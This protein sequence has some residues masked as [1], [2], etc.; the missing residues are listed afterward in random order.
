MLTSMASKTSTIRA[1]LPVRGKGNTKCHIHKDNDVLLLC[2]DCKVLICLT[3]SLSTHKA[4]NGSFVELSET[5]YQN[6]NIIL[7]FINETDKVNIPKLNHEIT[8]SR[9]KITSCKP[10]YDKLRKDILD[11]SNQCKEELDLITAEYLS[12]CDMMEV[13]ATDRFQTHISEM[14][15][16]RE[17]LRELSSEYRQTIQT[18]TAIL[19]YDSVSE[20][21]ELDTDIPPAPTIDLAGFTPS[22]NRQSHIKQAMGNISIPTDRTESSSSPV[23]RP[24]QSAGQTSEVGYNLHPTVMSQFSYP[25]GVTSVCPTSDGYAWLCDCKN[26][27]V[28]LITYKGQVLQK[29]KHIENIRD[30]SLDPTTGRLWFCCR[31]GKIVCE[32][33]TSSTP[34]T[35]FTTEYRPYSLCVTREGRVVVGTGSREQGYKVVMYTTD[36]RMLHTAILKSSGIGFVQSITQC[37]VT[38]NIAVISSNY[39]SGD[40]ANPHN[41]IRHVIVYNQ[42]LQDLVIYRGEDI[43][44]TRWSYLRRFITPDKFDPD[45]VVYDSRGNLVIADRST[46]TIELIS[47]SGK[48]IETLHTNKSG[49]QTIGVQTDDVLWATGDWGFKLLKYYND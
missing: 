16:R 31:E 12:L 19:M 34:V 30:I 15:G 32:V 14:K 17:R 2:Q 18:G 27:S 6:Q 49:H 41:Y 46:N 4:H 10:L 5:K 33:S 23:V 40:Y 24:K 35:R 48:Y 20:I 47:G 13:A 25:D 7:D 28:K 42:T 43:P 21:L 8:T 29:N 26:G 37:G 11:H 9:T 44:Q 39:I 22:K 1:Q 3:C 45:R 38:G 36:G